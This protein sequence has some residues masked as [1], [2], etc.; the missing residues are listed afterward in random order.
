[1]LLRVSLSMSKFSESLF[2]RDD[3]NGL[4]A[5]M[6]EATVLPPI[7]D[8]VDASSEESVAEVV[9]EAAESAG[10]DEVLSESDVVEGASSRRWRILGGG[11]AVA[12]MWPFSSMRTT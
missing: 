12:P 4:R 6:I 5:A 11:R 10:D 8:V 9:E 7:D 3:A 1:M 2:D